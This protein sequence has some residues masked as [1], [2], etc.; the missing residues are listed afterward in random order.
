MAKALT[1]LQLTRLLAQE[2]GLDNKSAA[3]FLEA[4][5]TIAARE[6]ARRG[7]FTL[8]R[9]CRIWS[10][11]REERQVR[12]P[13]TGAIMTRPADRQ[14]RVRVFNSFSDAVND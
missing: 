14:V 2:A 6:T 9:I 3:A 5:V 7:V 11:A 10:R 12:H 13:G 1:K 4:L 8:P